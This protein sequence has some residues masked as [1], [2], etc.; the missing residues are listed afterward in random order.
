[1]LF[2][3]MLAIVDIMFAP[4]VTEDDATYV[5]ALIHDHHEDFKVL[6][7]NNSIIPKM[8]FMVHMPRLSLNLVYNLL[9]SPW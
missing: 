4:K 5:A 7:P 9:L 3:K 6:Y 2:L 8:H 1:M